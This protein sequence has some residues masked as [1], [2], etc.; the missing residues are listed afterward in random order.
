MVTKAKQKACVHHWLIDD[1]HQGVCKYCLAKK[2]FN[3]SKLL[4]G[5]TVP[6]SRYRDIAGVLGGTYRC[7]RC[8]R[9]FPMYT[10]LGGNGSN[11]RVRYSSGQ[12]NF[13]RHL[14]SCRG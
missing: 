4:A 12:A 14:R 9:S 13:E 3:P 1:Q 2:D 8:D 5:L 6:D 10:R 11:G 7:P